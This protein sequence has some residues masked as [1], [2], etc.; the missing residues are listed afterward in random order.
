ML[1]ADGV[2]GAVGQRGE[3]ARRHLLFGRIPWFVRH[4]AT[5]T[6]HPSIVAE[7]A[8]RVSTSREPTNISQTDDRHG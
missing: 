5:P 4:Q 1:T 7:R 6:R 2:G 3:G 8:R